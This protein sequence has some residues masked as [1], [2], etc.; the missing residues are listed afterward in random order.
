M[1][2][3]DTLMTRGFVPT[4]VLVRHY[5]RDLGR[6][7]V[8]SWSPLLCVFQHIANGIFTAPSSFSASPLALASRECAPHLQEATLFP[9]LARQQPLRRL[10]L[11]FASLARN[12]GDSGSSP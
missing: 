11:G 6:T 5:W 12:R 9:F 2:A 1:L 7:K 8:R 3:T 4:E 10:A